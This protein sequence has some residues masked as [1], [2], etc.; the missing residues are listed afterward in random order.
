MTRQGVTFKSQNTCIT[1]MVTFLKWKQFW[2]E[3]SNKISMGNSKF[4][5]FMTMTRAYLMSDL[6]IIALYSP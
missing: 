5:Y 2:G 1:Q 4:Y 6:D 3:R